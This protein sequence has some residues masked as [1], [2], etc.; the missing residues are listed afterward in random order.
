MSLFMTVLEL[1]LHGKQNL[2]QMPLKPPCWNIA[3]G[4]IEKPLVRSLAMDL[5]ETYWAFTE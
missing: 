1:P 2:N 4:N 5:C 3:K